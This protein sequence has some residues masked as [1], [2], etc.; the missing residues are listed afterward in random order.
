M[1]YTANVNEL[2]GLSHNII[3]KSP[4]FGIIN[5]YIWISIVNLTRNQLCT[6]NSN[7]LTVP[8]LF[9]HNTLSE[10]TGKHHYNTEQLENGKNNLHYNMNKSLKSLV[11]QLWWPVKASLL[12]ASHNIH[13]PIRCSQCHL[14]DS[15]VT[16]LPYSQIRSMPHWNSRVYD[17]FSSPKSLT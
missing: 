2:K 10:A 15:K 12:G 14:S 17:K 8:V 5:C 3:H 16:A 4:T 6:E 11:Q 9:L 1:K 7:H 13:S